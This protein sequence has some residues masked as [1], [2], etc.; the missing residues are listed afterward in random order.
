MK[1]EKA[2]TPR[3]PARE[4]GEAE[5]IGGVEGEGRSAYWRRGRPVRNR[6]GRN[7]RGKVYESR[8]YHLSGLRAR[9]RADAYVTVCAS[10]GSG[11]CEMYN[12]NQMRVGGARGGRVALGQAEVIRTS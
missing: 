3:G 7:L 5:G 2:P 6:R 8:L 9:M 10:A 4:K 11:F 12:L 1:T